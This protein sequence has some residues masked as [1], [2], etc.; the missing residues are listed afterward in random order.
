GEREG[1]PGGTRFGTLVHAVLAECPLSADARAVAAMARHQ[2]RLLDAPDEEVVAATEAAEAALA[3]PILVAARAAEA[4]GACRRECP[5]TVPLDD[6]TSAEGVV[7]LA[8]RDGERWVV[9][10]F[11]TDREIGDKPVHAAQLAIYARAVR[12]ATG[13]EVETVLLYV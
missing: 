8:Y 11:K 7:D 13:R 5:I 10:D 2:G 3:H 12:A 1:R 6:G 9:V 4:R